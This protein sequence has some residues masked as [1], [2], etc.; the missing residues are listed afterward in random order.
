MKKIKENVLLINL[1]MQKPVQNCDKT[2]G[3]TYYQKQDMLQIKKT[4][5]KRDNVSVQCG[6][7][8]IEKISFPFIYNVIITN[9]HP[10]V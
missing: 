10:L 6:C 2:V 1:T 7:G 5:R 9:T 4:K 8:Y 3:R